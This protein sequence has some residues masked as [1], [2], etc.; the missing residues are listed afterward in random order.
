MRVLYVSPAY[1]T[2]DR[3]FVAELTRRGHVVGYLQGAAAK[4]ESRPLPDGVTILEG[5]I[6]QAMLSFEPDITQAGPVPTS[7]YAAARANARPLV[8]VSWG[9]DLLDMTENSIGY[10][11]YA[12]D[13]SDVFLCDCA[14]V[15]EA[16]LRIS[17]ISKD[18]IV[19][20]P[21]GIELH[22][23]TP[24]PLRQQV[25][26]IISTRVWEAEYA[27]ET[28]L[29]AFALAHK[30]VPALRLT[31]LGG[32][33]LEGKLY[34]LVRENKM[35]TVVTMK[36]RVAEH[37][38]PAHLAAADLYVSAAPTDGSSISLLEALAAGLPVIAT[39]RP[40]NREWITAGINGWLAKSGDAISFSRAIVEAA[41]TS[42]EARQRMHNSNVVLAS[43]RADWNWHAETYVRA[44][45]AAASAVRI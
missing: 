6:E 37:E 31:L 11:R 13:R 36:G 22:R 15:A 34:R 39:D 43:S 42:I 33:S 17:S 35:E 38:L 32:G 44:L 26:N 10:A 25:R 16:A 21:W 1:T 40:S 19:Q 12:L 27:V 4:L 2:H 7:A 28:V 24:A 3:R 45:E 5:S 29:A 18:R 8:S 41:N 14:E 30:S 20:F 9:S 23:F